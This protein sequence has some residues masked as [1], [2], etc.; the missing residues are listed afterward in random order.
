MGSWD[1]RESG[2]VLF[3][4][5]IAVVLFAALSYAVTQSSRLSGENST[6]EKAQLKLSQAI[7][8]VNDVQ[9]AVTR[10]R[11]SGCAEDQISFENS[12]AQFYVNPKAPADKSCHVFRPEG[13]NVVFQQIPDMAAAKGPDWYRAY[14]VFFA[15]TEVYG[16]GMTG[17][18]P[19][20]NDLAMAAPITKEMCDLIVQQ[21]GVP[22]FE[23]GGYD[24]FNADPFRGS[25]A[26][27]G[28]TVPFSN[29]VQNGGALCFRN[30]S[31][32]GAQ[33]YYLQTLIAR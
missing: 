16:Q 28:S 9:V 4:I 19:D 21:L 32:P 3:L 7:D 17:S 18:R 11:A 26:T 20:S 5:L 1:Y 30:S 2:N 23:D 29:N 6:K 10:L 33:Y 25:Y 15:G 31:G 8:F 27:R 12:I 14:Y 13:G 22:L 24:S